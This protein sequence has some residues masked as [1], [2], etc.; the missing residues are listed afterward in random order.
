MITVVVEEERGRGRGRAF[1]IKIKI[2]QKEKRF[3]F[4]FCGEKN[5]QSRSETT[6]LNNLRFDKAYAIEPYTG[7]ISNFL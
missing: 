5:Y 7:Q 6:F 4:L 3:F 2:L 1:I